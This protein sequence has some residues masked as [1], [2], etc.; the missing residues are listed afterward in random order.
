[1]TGSEKVKFA[2]IEADLAGIIKIDGGYDILEYMDSVD[3]VTTNLGCDTT[4]CDA[5][6]TPMSFEFL[7]GNFA[8]SGDVDN[9]LAAIAQN[10]IVFHLSPE[11]GGPESNSNPVNDSEVSEPA[12]FVILAMGLAALGRRGRSRK[13]L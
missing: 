1:M 13:A 3:Y 5:S 4:D 8:T 10:G 9:F 12:T 7:F 2:G 11:R 6:T